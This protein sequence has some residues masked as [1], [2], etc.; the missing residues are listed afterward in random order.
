MPI[1]IMDNWKDDGL[2]TAVFDASG[3]QPTGESGKKQKGK[4]Q[5]EN[6]RSRRVFRGRHGLPVSARQA[7]VNGG[8]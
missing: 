5:K 7:A 8:A 4:N 2:S 6:A 1:R 3:E